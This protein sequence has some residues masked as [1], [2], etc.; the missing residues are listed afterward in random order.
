MGDFGG[1][2][3]RCRVSARAPVNHTPFEALRTIQLPW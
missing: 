1:K 2:A 3:M